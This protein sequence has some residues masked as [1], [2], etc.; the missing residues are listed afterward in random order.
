MGDA[1]PA[2]DAQNNHAQADQHEGGQRPDV[3]QLCQFSERH[4]A[5]DQRHDDAAETMTRT[6]VCVFGLT[7][8]KN[9]KQP[10]RDMAKIMRVRP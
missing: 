6:G 1:N 5:C 4:Q 8:G 2:G 3:D 10:S 7:F 9:G